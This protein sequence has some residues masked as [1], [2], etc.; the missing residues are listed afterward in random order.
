MRGAKVA[1]AIA[2]EQTLPFHV[3]SHIGVE[4]DKVGQPHEV[5]VSPERGWAFFIG[6]G[7]KV[8]G[9]GVAAGRKNTRPFEG[10]VSKLLHHALAR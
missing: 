7:Y 2:F 6:D 9:K 10:K 8:R 3:V 1:P 4:H 5:A